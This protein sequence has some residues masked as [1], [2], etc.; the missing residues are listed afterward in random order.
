MMGGRGFRVEELKIR[1]FVFRF[2]GLVHTIHYTVGKA[3]ILIPFLTDFIIV[4]ETIAQVEVLRVK[5]FI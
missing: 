5:I 1:T 4:M 3:S 2:L